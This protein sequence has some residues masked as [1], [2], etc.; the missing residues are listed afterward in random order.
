[1]IERPVRITSASRPIPPEIVAS[2]GLATEDRKLHA[3]AAMSK[4]PLLSLAGLAGAVLALT[5]LGCRNDDRTNRPDETNSPG[6]T[7]APS[8]VSP[9]LVEDDDEIGDEDEVGHDASDAPG[10]HHYETSPVDSDMP[11]G[12]DPKQPPPPSQQ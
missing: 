12:A 7:P 8:D 5:V 6:A 11:E 9:P 4:Q 1:M 2:R 10:S 3:A